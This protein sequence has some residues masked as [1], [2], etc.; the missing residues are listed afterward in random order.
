[1]ATT[2]ELATRLSRASVKKLWNVYEL[3]DWADSL[4]CSGSWCMPPEL[5]SLYATP[6]WEALSGPQRHRLSFFEIVNFFSFVLR[7]ERP[8][9]MGLSQHMY[10]RKVEPEVNQYLHHFLDEENKHMVMFA[11]F[12]QRYA[13]KIYPEKKLVLEREFAPGEEQV[14]FFVKVLVFEELGDV[15][16]VEIARDERVHP[17]VRDINRVHH[18]DEARHIAFGRHYLKQLFDEAAP[19]WSSETLGNLRTWLSDYLH[20]TWR[21]FYNP[22]VYRDAEVE[23]AFRARQLALDSPACQRHRERVSRK[24]VSYLLECGILLQEPAL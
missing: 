14:I 11:E 7:G 5:V 17:L 9:L 13:G 6:A 4:D 2:T 22:A 1:M 23:D 3:F 21:D 8:L 18:E 19:N 12:C 16:N 24:L 20:S 15:Y 10:G